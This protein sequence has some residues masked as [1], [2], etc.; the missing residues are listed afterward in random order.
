MPKISELPVYSS[1]TSDA[2]IP[3]VIGGQT[4]RISQE[5]LLSNINEFIT[6]GLSDKANLVGGNTFSGT[7]TFSNNI[8]FNGTTWTYGSGAALAHKTALSLNNVDNTS[9]TSK[10]ISTLTQTALNTKANLTGGN[11]ITGQQNIQDLLFVGQGGDGITFYAIAGGSGF[12]LNRNSA[13]G[14]IINASKPAYQF[15]QQNNGFE[16]QE[17]SG[18]GAF[19]GRTFLFNGNFG[20]VGTD[21]STS[22]TN[23]FW[24]NGNASI[25]S[26]TYKAATAP[27]NGL[28]V[29][30]AIG[31][32]TS[33]LNASAKVQIDS[34]TQGFLPPR[35]T[36]TQR[37]AISSPAAGLMIFNT[38]TAK[39]NF[40]NGS[41]WEAV[42]SV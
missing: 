1:A 27:T 32:G 31:I 12:A 39:L 4:F 14:A 8:V 30:G 7:Q 19:I 38:T 28:I 23:R 42:T 5:F 26:A 25:G 11:T 13:T 34:T 37:N 20:V 29:E 17:Y 41:A 15:G 36:T 22:T 3:V 2:T 10:P 21:S 16:C 40:Y 33:S 18:A 9:D 35:L 24:V 6:D